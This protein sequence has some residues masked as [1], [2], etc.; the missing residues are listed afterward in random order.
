[1]TNLPMK[2]Y[3][4]LPLL[5][6]TVEGILAQRPSKQTVVMDD[7]SRIT[8]TIISDSSDFIRIKVRRAS[9]LILNKSRVVSAGKPVNPYYIFSDYRGYNIN[10]SAGILAG[11]SETCR[12]HSFSIH[13]SCGYLFRNGLHIGLGT[14]IEEYDAMLVPVYSDLRYHPFRSRISPFLWV[15]TGY[16]F[17]VSDYKSQSYYYGYNNG[18]TSGGIMLNAGVG[19]AVCSWRG[20][21]V[22]MGAGYR[23]QRISYTEPA[24]FWRQEVLRE[25]VK[26]FNRFEIRI[27]YIFR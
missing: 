5:V 8:G 25:I 6:L 18:K 16:A 14:G 26:N 19:S 21:G 23:F 27:G 3:L 20:N 10:F 7:G 24:Y 13:S 2:K 1:M 4:I 15:K 12:V 11:D 9:E 22:F 17:P